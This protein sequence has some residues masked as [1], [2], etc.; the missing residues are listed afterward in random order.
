LLQFVIVSYYFLEIGNLDDFRILQIQDLFFKLEVRKASNIINHNK[1]IFRVILGLGY[2][3]IK[4]N[5]TLYGFRTFEETEYKYTHYQLRE[6]I[7]RI[8]CFLS[9]Y[10]HTICKNIRIVTTAG[11]EA[12]TLN[13]L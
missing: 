8:R 3:F 1:A 2:I 11:F 12:L 6:V 7:G 9:I 13:K 4:R 5:I 10:F